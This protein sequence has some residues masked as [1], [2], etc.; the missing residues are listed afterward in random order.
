M[1]RMNMHCC[2]TSAP[3]LAPCR[4]GGVPTLQH[5]LPRLLVLVPERPLA[6]AGHVPR[7][8]EQ[9][10]QQLLE[11]HL[12]LQGAH[13]V[14]QALF[15][16]VG[17]RRMQRIPTPC[18]CVGAGDGYRSCEEKR[19][20]VA[21]SPTVPSNR[22]PAENRGTRRECLPA[23]RP[24]AFPAAPACAAWLPPPRP[25]CHTFSPRPG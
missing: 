18:T 1:C 6:R 4:Y 9:L 23:A 12:L 13:L 24:V 25:R 16:L 5:D 22:P 8:Y 19:A 7:R 10:A 3:H 15:L 20:R 2:V 17:S 14:Q 11:L 21:S